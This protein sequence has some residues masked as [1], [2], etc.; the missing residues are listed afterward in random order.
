M[1]VI[2]NHHFLRT[3]IAKCLIIFFLLLSNITFAQDI[4]RSKLFVY[5]Q[6]NFDSTVIYNGYSSWGVL[7]HLK[8]ISKEKNNISYYAFRPLLNDSGLYYQP[9]TNK[10]FKKI[11]LENIVENWDRLLQTNI[12]NTDHYIRSQLKSTDNDGNVRVYFISDGD[13]H[14]FYF[15]TKDTIRKL[16]YYAPRF[17][18]QYR[19][20]E[21]LKNGIRAIDIFR[22]IFKD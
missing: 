11:M 1:L 8:I 22:D 12:W 7:P 2:L 9:D 16:Y 3:A 4:S 20:D 5:F 19:P 15:L 14:D 13:E 17:Y 6:N 18:N 10:Y 21:K